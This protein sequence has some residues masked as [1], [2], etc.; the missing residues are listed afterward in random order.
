MSEQDKAKVLDRIRKL[1]ALS[2][3][4]NE[5]E[6]AAAADKA[7]A[8]LAQYNLSALDLV[9]KKGPTLIFDNELVTESR[10]WLR[11]IVGACCKLY[12]CE[13]YYTFTYNYR[14][15]AAKPNS[16]VR[17]DTWTI[18]GDVQ[19]VMV[20]KMM[21]TYLMKAVERLASEAGANQPKAAKS[22]FLQAFKMGAAARLHIRL[23]RRREEAM[24][25]QMKI[26][27]GL[28]EGGKTNLP[29][30]RSMYEVAEQQ[31]KDAIQEKVGKMGK[32]RKT[33]VKSN[34]GFAA[35]YKAGDTIGLDQQVGGSTGTNKRLGHS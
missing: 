21:A 33:T 32:N 20:A 23:Y 22:A 19:N 25:G 7:Q 4:P 1:M 31:A 2:E 9:E 6:A 8:L 14:S 16:Y 27:A 18:V 24:A 5:H 10:P 26:E 15:G 28:L 3:S 11:P 17:T 34:A 29:A 30:L 12:F 35:G 13:T